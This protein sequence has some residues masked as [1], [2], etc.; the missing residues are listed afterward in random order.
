MQRGR[1]REQLAE[2]DGRL[3]AVEGDDHRSD[4]MSG[5]CASGVERVVRLDCGDLVRHVHESDAERHEP[6]AI[7][8]RDDDLA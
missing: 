1:E 5:V 2:I 8:H 6:L 3:A 7:G 4:V